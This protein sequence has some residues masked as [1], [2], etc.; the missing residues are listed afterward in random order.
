MDMETFY[1]Y[2]QTFEK[3]IIG[4]LN[5]KMQ[6]G[7]RFMFYMKLVLVW[8]SSHKILLFLQKVTKFEKLNPIII[9]N[10]DSSHS[11]RQFAKTTDNID[12]DDFRHI[13]YVHE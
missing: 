13:K 4:K 12:E 7:E 1:R 2:D 8:I 9:V 10:W 3:A 11:E 6:P 5:P